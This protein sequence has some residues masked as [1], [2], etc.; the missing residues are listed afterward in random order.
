LPRMVSRQETDPAICGRCGGV[1]F[2]RDAI[3]Y[4]SGCSKT[5]VGCTC[6]G[7]RRQERVTSQNE[8]LLV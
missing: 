2:V 5:T 8:R 7:D 4:C 1:G 3:R 6:R